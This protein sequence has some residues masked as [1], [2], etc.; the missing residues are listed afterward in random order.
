L[1]QKAG[2][3]VDE[4][5]KLGAARSRRR[6]WGTKGP[7]R[8]SPI[9]IS[10]RREASKRPKARAGSEVSSLLLTPERAR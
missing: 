7:M 5:E 2:V 10:L 1:D 4:Q 9:Q 3:V 8:T 6:G